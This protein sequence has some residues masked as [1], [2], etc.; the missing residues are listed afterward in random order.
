LLGNHKQAF[1]HLEVGF[2]HCIRQADMKIVEYDDADPV[3]V[4]HLNLLSLGW[5]LTP[6]LAARIR[7]LDPR[8]FPFFG[9]YAIEE[10]MV[11]GQVLVYRLPAVTS[12]GPEA[13]GGV[14]AVAS[15]PAFRHRGIAVRL[16]DEAH[17]R[18][19]TAGLRFSSLLTARHRMAH[20]LYQRVGYED[21]FAFGSAFARIRTIPISSGLRA[22]RAGE[23]RLAIADGLFREAAAGRLGFA[24][25]HEP[26]FPVITQLGDLDSTNIWLLMDGDIAVG[27][28]VASASESIL[29]VSDLLL[30]DG[31]DPVAAVTAIA[32]AV[33]AE[34]LQ[35]RINHP[36]E[37][38]SF[39][40]AGFQM[41]QPAWGTFMVKPLVSKVTSEDARRLFGIGTDRFLIS[42]LDTT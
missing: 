25:R 32:R 41:A 21:V 24:W 18:M 14:A 40:R 5:P 23:E 16:M 27:C 42:W 39:E 34:Y 13:V 12:E 17:T 2:H 7:R 4:L 33:E 35:V 3:G 10:G 15:H 11:A 37:A 22:E 30:K 36:A 9:V 8:P 28:A 26:F 1:D 6:E 29:N 31:I 38:R 20:L 19:R